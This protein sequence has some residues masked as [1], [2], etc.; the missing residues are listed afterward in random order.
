MAEEEKTREE[1]FEEI[2]PE[3]ELVAYFEILNLINYFP[4]G[5]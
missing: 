2:K 5:S 4:G 3:E 1:E